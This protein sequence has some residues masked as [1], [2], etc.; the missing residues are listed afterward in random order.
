MNR[1]AADGGGC[2]AGWRL[3]ALDAVDST[4]TEARRAL[5]APETAALW[6]AGGLAVH[7]SEQI[8][9]RGR[10]G[11]SWASPPGNLY[12]TA[13]IPCPGGPRRGVEVGFVGGVALA[14]ALDD[15]GVAG[16]RLKWPNDVLID[17]AKVAGLLPESVTDAAGRFWILL[18]MGLNV[19]HAPAAGQTLYPATS[20]ARVAGAAGTGVPS[21]P[22]L[23]DAL[24]TRLA[25]ALALWRADG[26]QPVRRAWLEVGH[27]LG[28]PVRVR[29]G[30]ET[31]TGI[32]LGLARDGALLLRDAATGGERTVLAGDVF[33]PASANGEG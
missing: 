3:I 10:H 26:F 7:A 2:P 31:V 28:D 9:G 17:G 13:A 20:L 11:R 4:Q 6:P 15:L 23:R 32:F 22:A 29:L 27:G 5:D 24:L 16:V 25:G 30:A 8:G 18:G 14:R 19:T 12:V 21:V 33:F 1:P